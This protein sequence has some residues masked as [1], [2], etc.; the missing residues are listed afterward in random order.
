M[1][2]ALCLRRDSDAEVVKARRCGGVGRDS[3]VIGK[4]S[5]KRTVLRVSVARSAKSVRKLCTGAPLAET[6]TI[7]SD[8]NAK[9]GEH[10]GTHSAYWSFR[11]LY[12]LAKEC[13]EDI[14]S[15]VIGS[16]RS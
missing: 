4:A 10:F 6:S 8:A 3:T 14:L 5:P 11:G 12:A 15:E 2:G 7:S 1:G 16:W 9:G 13:G